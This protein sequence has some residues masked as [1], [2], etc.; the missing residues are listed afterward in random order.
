[1]MSG[2]W[3]H[4]Y[5]RGCSNLSNKPIIAITPLYNHES[6]TIRM[7]NRY[8]N[9]VAKYG[10]APIVLTMCE[11]PSILDAFVDSFDG[12][13][14]SGGADVNPRYYGEEIQAFCGPTVPDYDRMEM[15]LIRKTIEAGKPIFG[16]CRGLQIL[17]VALGGTLYQDIHEQCKG[18]NLHD[19]KT[20]F[21]ELSHEIRVEPDS[22]LHRCM[23]KDVL[24]VN[25][26]HHQAIKEVAPDLRTTAMS[27]DGLVEAV[28]HRTAPNV[29]AVQY[30][31]EELFEHYPEHGAIF[32]Y[33]IDL[34]R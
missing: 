22:I 20:R 31:P 33:F 15:A 17:N 24:E 19:Q 18:K 6:Y 9:A 3:S 32:Q 12:V 4:Y 11:D 14:L 28:E 1:M 23:G 27:M 29:F 13:I 16:I 25:T 30:H 26:L 5:A 2:A 21:Y 8:V 10:G 34:C 7:V